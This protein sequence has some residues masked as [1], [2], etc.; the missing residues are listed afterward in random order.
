MHMHADTL[1]KIYLHIYMYISYTCA[2]NTYIHINLKKGGRSES[3]QLDL[4]RL[5]PFHCRAAAPLFFVV[6]ATCYLCINPEMVDSD[7]LIIEA[8][9][10]IVFN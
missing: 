3:S 2:H 4:T 9:S 6:D 1:Y 10:L 5:K 7:E 8:E